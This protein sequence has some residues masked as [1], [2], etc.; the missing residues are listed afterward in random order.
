MF[1]RSTCNF[2]FHGKSK[3][4]FIDNYLN[5]DNFTE[6]VTVV[7]QSRDYDLTFKDEC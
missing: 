3:L 4:L 5:M 6:L 1:L 2:F 7:V